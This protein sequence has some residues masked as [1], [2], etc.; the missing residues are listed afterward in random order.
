MTPS[1]TYPP[2]VQAVIDAGGSVA[3]IQQA[4]NAAIAAGA[5]PTPAP[6]PVPSVNG[7]TLATPAPA[8]QTVTT[9]VVGFN[10]L[11]AWVSDPLVSDSIPIGWW[12]LGIAAAFL[13]YAV[14]GK[15]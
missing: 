8:D 6:G 4:V 15:R 1:P 10:P 3:Q 12:E 5:T 11:S 14:G 2:S 7:T 9:Q 13:L